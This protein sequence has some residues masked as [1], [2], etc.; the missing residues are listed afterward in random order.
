MQPSEADRLRRIAFVTRAYGRLRGSIKSAFVVPFAMLAIQGDRNGDSHAVFLWVLALGLVGP[1]AAGVLDYWMN[2][3]FGRVVKSERS[4][5]AWRLWLPLALVF[6]YSVLEKLDT[7]ACSVAAR[8]GGLSVVGSWIAACVGDFIL[9]RAVL[10]GPGRA[11]A[12]RR[13]E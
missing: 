12:L 11:E 8:A 13:S 3:R 4:D 6:A 10:A 7:W 2:R 9:V 5:D 1:A